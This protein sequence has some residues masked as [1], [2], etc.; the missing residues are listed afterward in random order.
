MSDSRKRYLI[1]EVQ[2]KEKAQD[3]GRKLFAYQ[4]SPSLQTTTMM[5]MVVAVM[6]IFYAYMIAG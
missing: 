5:M 1:L 4:L 3:A 2:G 6:M